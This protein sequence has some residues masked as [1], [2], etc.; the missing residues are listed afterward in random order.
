MLKILTNNRLFFI[1]FFVWVIL[2]SILQ[3]LFS[4][5]EIMFWI[6]QHH[7]SL[8]DSFF[9]YVTLLGEDTIWLALFLHFAFE[10]YIKGIENN[11]AIKVLLI[12]W[13][14]KVLVSVSLKNIFNFP[15]PIEVYQHSDQ[16]I[17][18]V[19]GVTMHH[20]QS[21]PSGHTMTAFTFACVCLFL[22]KRTSPA[23]IALI[24]AMLVGYSRMY[25]FQHFPRDVFAGSVLGVGVSIIVFI[26][27]NKKI[28]T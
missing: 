22:Q 26:L 8:L 7:N 9:Y 15:R 3:L 21:F 12:T 2:G 28:T 20:W 25:L 17:H 24:I 16:A 27:S 11:Q 23:I 19:D 14:S 10:K 5:T 13:L 4:P 18:L 6:N 1:I